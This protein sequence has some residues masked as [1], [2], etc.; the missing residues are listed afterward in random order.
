MSDKERI[1]KWQMTWLAS[2]WLLVGVV[3]YL[4]L[5]RLDVDI[6]AGGGDKVAHMLA[7]A[8]MTYWF[9]Q[10]YVTPRSRR[11]IAAVLVVLGV[12]LEFLQGETGYRTFDYA[13]M[14]AN[15]I[16]VAAGWIASP[17]RTPS[18]LTRIQSYISR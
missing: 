11:S 3:V 13:D 1:S 15:T 8:T 5:V 18:V 4:S 2:A 16:G 12:V 14:I 9:M 6:P 7:Y 17:P 10:V